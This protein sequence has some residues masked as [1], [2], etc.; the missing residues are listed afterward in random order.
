LLS[1]FAFSSFITVPKTMRE[2]GLAHTINDQI[3]NN[4]KFFSLRL[5]F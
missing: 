1:I 3:R 5:P 2:C 4:P